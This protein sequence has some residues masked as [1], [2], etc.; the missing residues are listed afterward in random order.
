[1]IVSLGDRHPKS[2]S[3]PTTTTAIT[4]FIEVNSSKLK[5][6]KQKAPVWGPFLS[7][8]ILCSFD[9]PGPYDFPGWLGLEHHLLTRKRVD[10]FSRLGR[11]LLH[12]DELCEAGHQE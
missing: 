3:W 7:D 4:C 11:R 12:H 8:C 10:A 5:A 2:Y 6:L 1:K 9:R